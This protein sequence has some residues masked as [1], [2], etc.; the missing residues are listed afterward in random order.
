MRILRWSLKDVGPFKGLVTVDL[1]KVEGTIV[2]LVGENGAGKTT[3]LELAVA[4]AH[5]D[6]KTVTRGPLAGLATTR[7][8]FVATEVEVDGARYLLTHTADAVSGKGESFVNDVEGRPVLKTNK[9]SEFKAWAATHLPDPEV[10]RVSTLKAQKSG[11]FLALGAAAR[12]DV[13]L[14]VLGAAELEELATLARARGNAAKAE[15]AQASARLQDEETRCTDTVEAATRVL[16]EAEGLAHSTGVALTQARQTL[17]EGETRF[18]HADA[19]NKRRADAAARVERAKT[20]RDGFVTRVANNER[21]LDDAAKIRAALARQAALEA[22]I[23]GMDVVL[24]D[25]K[26]AKDVVDAELAPSEREL[27]SVSRER[28]EK[29][30]TVAEADGVKRAL[31]LL[32]SLRE[33]VETA[34]SRVASHEAELERLRG[35]QVVS[36]EGRITNLRSGLEWIADADADFAPV[37]YKA[38]DTLAADDKAVADAKEL[39]GWLDAEK[40]RK[41]TADKEL[42]EASK[43]LSDHERVAD[44]KAAV[45][46]AEAAIVAL[47]TRENELRLRI[48]TLRNE[49][50]AHQTT[51]T[52]V[53][54]ARRKSADDLAA[55]TPLAKMAGPLEAAESRLEEL[56]PQL[57]AAEVEVAAAEQAMAAIAPVD[58]PALGAMR[59]A[60]E[61]AE[62]TAKGAEAALAV[63][64]TRKV[65]AEE[66]AERRSVLA[67]E[68]QKVADELADWARLTDDLGKKGLQAMEIDA[69]MPE[70]T[71]ITNDLLR[72]SFGSR[73]TLSFETQRANDKGVE[74]E[75]FDV[76][77]VDT[78]RGRDAQ[79]ETLS[80]GEGVIVDEAISLG[81][82]VFGAQRARLQHPTI[83][84]DEAGAALSPTNAPLWV[85][86]LR[87]AAAM[88]KADKVL[89]VSH[90]PAVNE[91]ADA[92]ILVGGGTMEITT[93]EGAGDVKHGEAA[94]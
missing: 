83:I 10:L 23:R 5:P 81:L 63:A 3:A 77:I 4:A 2:A 72:A 87:R 6:R 19:E 51:L 75:V 21:V 44:R 15:F 31:E 79:A 56:R 53:G 94:E 69:A 9:V 70:L 62:T 54:E 35:V 32:P 60:V 14:E 17:V 55:L 66:S 24:A 33:A 1:T 58:V 78:E 45:D 52:N 27:A 38:R 37:T 59:R 64:K 22:D 88:V 29:E 65:A 39:P 68:K 84:R 41:A 90:L 8:S 12:K 30:K 49:S 46:A 76:R 43:R 11:G 50:G 42:G 18:A 57:A 82:S 91:L 80:G 7:Q 25:T 85:A 48:Q 28:I 40:T 34:T 93:P 61:A 13:I 89:V 36:A 67:A 47:R 86:M 74:M 73:W 20:N 71:E 16:S 26:R 92:W